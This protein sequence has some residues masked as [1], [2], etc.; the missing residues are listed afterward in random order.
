MDGVTPKTPKAESKE[1]DANHAIVEIEAEGVEA[2][3]EL[4]DLELSDQR[5]VDIR[6][7]R[8]KALMRRARAKSEQGGWGNLQGAEEGM[9][10]SHAD[11]DEDRA[12]F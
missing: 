9:H 3:R 5:R 12:K 7:I 6:R 11:T 8:A 1:D 4:A 10:W 2:E